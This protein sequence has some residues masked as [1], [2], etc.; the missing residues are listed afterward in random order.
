MQ[1]EAERV[2]ATGI[3]GGDIKIEVT[4]VNDSANKVDRPS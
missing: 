4:N 3:T 1:A 2:Q